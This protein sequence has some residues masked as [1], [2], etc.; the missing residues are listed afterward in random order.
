MTPDPA[1]AA[2]DQECVVGRTPALADVQHGAARVAQLLVGFE[3]ANRVWLERRAAPAP[4]YE[5]AWLNG[6]P[7][8]LTLLADRLLFATVLDLDGEPHGE[9]RVAGLYRVMNPAKLARLG[10]PTVLGPGE[11][12]GDRR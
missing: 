10:R 1:I 5:F 6:Q 9:P 2:D 12:L 8:V 11:T 7:A 4:A 3:R